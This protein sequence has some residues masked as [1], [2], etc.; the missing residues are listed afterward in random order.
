MKT[1]RSEMIADLHRQLDGLKNDARYWDLRR[2]Y[3]D[4]S[5]EVLRYLTE[6]A[7]WQNAWDKYT[8]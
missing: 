3:G 7:R 5:V 2:T 6:C 8:A 4:N 1:T